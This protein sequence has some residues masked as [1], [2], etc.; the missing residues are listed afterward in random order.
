MELASKGA[1]A[2]LPASFSQLLVSMKWTTAADFDIG[3]LIEK[4]DGSKDFVYFGNKG[5]LTEPPFIQVSEDQGVGDTGGDNE[6][7][8][9]IGSL[10]DAKTVHILCWDYGAVQ[11]GEKARFSESDIR[12]QVTDDSGTDH[13]ATLADSDAANVAVLATIETSAVGAKLINS[14]KV[15]TLKGFNKSDQL[16]EIVEAA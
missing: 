6:E 16:W 7:T 11:K 2:P 15:G 5:K 12:L 9:R 8:L 4:K 13:T 14:S 10:D 3:A 1:S